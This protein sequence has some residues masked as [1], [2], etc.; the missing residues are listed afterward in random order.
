MS[1]NCSH[2]GNIGAWRTMVMGKL[3]ICPTQFW[4]SYQQ[5]SSSKAGRT[6]IGNYEFCLIKYLFHT[7]KYSLTCHKRLWH[8]ANGFTSLP[9]EGVLQTSI[10]LRW[11]W[12]RKPWVQWQTHHWGRLI[13]R[14]K[15]LFINH[16]LDQYYQMQWTLD[17]KEEYWEKVN[18]RCYMYH[19]NILHSACSLQ[20][21]LTVSWW[22]RY[23]SIFSKFRRYS[24]SCLMRWS[25]FS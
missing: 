25:M 2:P 10:A 22:L 23:K 1:L 24:S 19:A 18:I 8:G 14:Y 16:F 15:S 5:S 17:H 9:K 13:S 3:S 7:S 11:V 21:I 12:T 20:S 6:G 4:Q